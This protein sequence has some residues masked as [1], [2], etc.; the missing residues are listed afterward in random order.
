[1]LE[2]GIKKLFINL[3]KFGQ[4]WKCEQLKLVT[5]DLNYLNHYFSN[6]I[7]IVKLKNRMRYVL[8]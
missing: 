6:E 2:E 4:M 7:E 8:V 3:Q 1:M 5:D